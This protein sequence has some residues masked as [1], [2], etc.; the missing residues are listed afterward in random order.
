MLVFD[1]ASA[2]TA[3]DSQF[4]TAHTQRRRSRAITTKKAENL[5]STRLNAN[6]LIYYSVSICEFVVLYVQRLLSNLNWEWLNNTD[7]RHWMNIMIPNIKIKMKI[8]DFACSTIVFK[9]KCVSE[10]KL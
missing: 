9:L 2:A 7:G 10:H 3:A 5:K 4:D 6:K 1:E 8:G